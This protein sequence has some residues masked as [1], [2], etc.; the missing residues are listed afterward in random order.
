MALG[1]HTGEGARATQFIKECSS[2]TDTMPTLDHTAFMANSSSPPKYRY[3]RRLPHLQKDDADM[4]ITFRTGGPLILTSEARDLVLQHCLREERV[5]LLAVVIMPNHVHLLLSCLRDEDGWPF[6]LS[7]IMQCLKGATAH[8]INR[9]LGSWRP[10]WQEESFD[11][12]LRS[13]ES[14]KE[15]IEYV[16]QNPVRAGLVER[17]EDYPWLWVRPDLGCVARVPS[18]V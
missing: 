13:H 15:K 6:P 16:R 9:L 18:P 11:H 8:R 7:K 14:L 12:V 3:R 5:H 4:F 10:V 2:V 1:R 17:P